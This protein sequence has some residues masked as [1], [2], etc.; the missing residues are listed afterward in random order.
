M[1]ST[2]LLSGWGGATR[3]AAIVHEPSTTAEIEAIVATRP[4][5]GLLARGCGR[6][7]GDAA[8][9]AGGHI[10]DSRRV[11]QIGRLDTATRTISVECGATLDAV[12]ASLVPAGWM[13]PVVPGTR[14]VS[15]GGAIAADVHGKNHPRSGTFASWVDEIHLVTP[16]GSFDIGPNRDAELFWATA[17]GMGLT[18]VIARATLRVVP[19]ESSWFETAT[20]KTETLE[21]TLRTLDQCPV[22]HALASIDPC[23]HP[24]RLGRAVVTA[25][26]PAPRASLDPERRR[27][28]LAYHALTDRPL[29]GGAQV[30][31]P[32]LIR[33]AYAARRRA[34]AAGPTERFASLDHFLFP[35][36]RAVAWNH[37]FGR[38]GL[39][40][41]QAV[42]PRGESDAIAALLDAY[43]RE[44]TASPLISLKR[45]GPANPGPLSFPMEGWTL[46]I[47]LPAGA[48]D[49][50]VFLD[51]LDAIVI[52]AGGRVY[53]AKDAR[54]RARSLRA[55]YP[56]LDEW[57][58]V[59]RRVDP[60]GVLR[61]DLA[62]R[63]HLVEEAL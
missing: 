12:L 54:L 13:L 49:L 23:T 18:G 16:A 20:W 63:L 24:D 36:D 17:G 47:D 40:Q 62:R 27:T 14:N 30:A 52:G 56:R 53:L 39:L 42:V 3:S 10:V 6:S 60:H 35:L 28:A 25:G 41:W 7:Y 8:L 2:Q 55:M 45:L 9:N 26:Q 43:A 22:E 44:G 31:R 51:R 46:A 4:Q 29:P 5:G 59:R 61:S 58:E 37:L 50:G 19:L 1:V 11:G 34:I 38:R 15:I 21:S 32:S 33:L 57:C 48:P